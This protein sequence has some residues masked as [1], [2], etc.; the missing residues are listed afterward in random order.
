VRT[1]SVI[2]LTLFSKPFFPIQI[3]AKLGDFGIFVAEV[4]QA[5]D[6]DLQLII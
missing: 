1:A 4:I 6:L 2:T 3:S 5:N